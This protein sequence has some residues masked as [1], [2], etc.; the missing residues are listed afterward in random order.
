MVKCEVAVRAKVCLKLKWLHAD[1]EW[2]SKHL[3]YR[4]QCNYLYMRVNI[5]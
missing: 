2:Q 4:V 3:P 5:K 1:V